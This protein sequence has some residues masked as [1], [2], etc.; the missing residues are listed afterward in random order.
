[1]LHSTTRAVVAALIAAL[2]CAA[3]LL[4]L[5]D[6]PRSRAVEFQQLVGGLGM[7]PAVDLARCAFSFDPRLCPDCP[8]N[9]EPIPGGACF[10]PHHACNVLSSHRPAEGPRDGRVP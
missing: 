4:V 3:I 1:M 5:C 2:T 6:R 9:H 7:G 8:W 10:C